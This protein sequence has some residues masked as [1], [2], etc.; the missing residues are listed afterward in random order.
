MIFYV[1][2]KLKLLMGKSLVFVN[3]IER[4]FQLKLFLER[5]SIR[6]AVL[7]ADLPQNSRYHIVHDFNCGNI[8]ILIATDAEVIDNKKL[9]L[10]ASR[11]LQQ[12]NQESDINEDDISDDDDDLDDDVLV[13]DDEIGDDELVDDGIGDDDSL[14]GDNIEDDLEDKVQSNEVQENER[15]K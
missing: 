8:E 6:S 15:K 12:E 3:T 5:L 7:N 14:E 10:A 1:L 9:K 13:V 11:L 4:C 2:L